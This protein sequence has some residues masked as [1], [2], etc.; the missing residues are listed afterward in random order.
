MRGNIT[1]RITMLWLLLFATGLVSFA[2][3]ASRIIANT[4]QEALD[5]ALETQAVAAAGSIDGATG[6]LENDVPN[7]EIGGFALV[8]YRDGEAHQILG[9]PPAS[10]ARRLAA[11][12]PAHSALTLP[13]NPQ[14]RV[15]MEASADTGYRIAAFAWERPVAEEASHLRRAFLVIGL[16]F[17]LLAAFAGWLLA[18]RSLA[19]IDQLAKTAAG[20][21][22]T[23]SFSTRFP[24]RSPDELGRLGATFNDMLDRLEASFERERAF[25]GDVSHELRQPLTAI[26]AE[27]DLPASDKDSSLKRIAHRARGMNNTLDDL[28]MLARADAGALAAGNAEVGDALAEASAE[29]RRQ[30]PAVE[31]RLEIEDAALVVGVAHSLLVRAFANLVRNAA[32]VA[33]KRVEVR[34]R[35]DDAFA[36]VTVEDDGPG[37]DP[38]DRQRIFRR[39]GRGKATV[40][41]GIGL[42]LPIAAA[43][44]EVAGGS[45]DASTA[46]TGGARFTIRLP[47][48]A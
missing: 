23:S 22:R 14:Y 34:V 20:V 9:P 21:A 2:A 48:R 46:P 35:R 12:V 17:L 5:A 26:S 19:P 13:T 30:F 38:S 11:G 43:V 33:R 18:R 10:K 28:L 4:S 15:V 37:I 1:A 47:L 29:V 42:G 41:A 3:L 32:Q 24:V 27:A 40:Y 31:L 7:V 25:I 6:R 45:V 36:V 16:P 44:F 8:V 39:F